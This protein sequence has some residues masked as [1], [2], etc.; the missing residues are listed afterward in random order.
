MD[1][2]TEGRC[3]RGDT[4]MQAT[5]V[6]RRV[7]RVEWPDD[8]ATVE[9]AIKALP[10]SSDWPGVFELLLDRSGPARRTALVLDGTDP[11]GVVLLRRI[12]RSTWELVTQWL[13]PGFLFPARPGYTFDVL[14]A[15]RTAV[16]V[17]LWRFPEP[18]PSRP[19]IHNLNVTATH[20]ICPKDAD[21]YW[22]ESG[23][24]PFLRH[25]RK[26]CQKFT[27]RINPEGGAEW[28]I[29][30]WEERWRKDQA[31]PARDLEDRVAVATFLERIGLHHT[32][33]LFDGETRIAGTT[34]LVH[35]D[36]L[37]AQVNHRVLDYERYGL[38]T[39]ML[40]SVFRW[41]AET[42]FREFDIGGGH[43]YKKLWAP[44]A[45]SRCEFTLSP[46]WL[47]RAQELAAYLRKIRNRALDFHIEP[48]AKPSVGMLTS[49]RCI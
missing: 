7:L 26:R 29:R 13:V 39:F 15:L 47:H 8:R 42:G 10:A 46:R 43:E 20:R 33:V 3:R 12:G 6:N 11:V 19:Q 27:L 41:A 9:D 48:G 2:T 28:V 18:P 1:A 35:D 31:A 37:V 23:N 45:G 36:V 17:G 38:G 44:F 24:Q 5:T 4:L 32:L 34:Q 16:H 21:A 30:H 40:E 25:A 14:E 49:S 22:K